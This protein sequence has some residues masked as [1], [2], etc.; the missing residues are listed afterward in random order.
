MLHPNVPELQLLCDTFTCVGSAGGYPN[1]SLQMK[2]SHMWA[3]LDLQLG[4]SEKHRPWPLV[5]RGRGRA[6]P[7]QVCPKGPS[8]QARDAPHHQELQEKRSRPSSCQPATTRSRGLSQSQSSKVRKI[9]WLLRL[10]TLQKLGKLQM[11]SLQVESNHQE[12][13]KAPY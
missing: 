8:A 10:Q 6:Q 4:P 5:A 1:L 7:F 9:S 12:D 13:S 2:D 3:K 11:K